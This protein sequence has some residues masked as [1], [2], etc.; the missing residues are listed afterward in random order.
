MRKGDLVF[1]A[2][3]GRG[4]VTQISPSRSVIM[5]NFKHYGVQTVLSGSLTVLV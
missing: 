4:L 5:V 3:F 2:E 1:H